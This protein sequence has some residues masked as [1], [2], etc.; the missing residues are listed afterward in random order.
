MAFGVG[1]TVHI[2]GGIINS[3]QK[4]N[5]ISEISR[6]K[7]VSI[8]AFPCPKVNDKGL[9]G[10]WWWADKIAI[11][12]SLWATHETWKAAKEEY[13]IGRRYYILAKEQWDHFYKYYR[14]LEDQELD[15]I[16]AELPYTPDYKTAVSGHTN[17]IDPVFI[18]TDA[19]L[20][21]LANK[22]CM[23]SDVSQFKKTEI[24]RST[25]RGDSDNF[26][27]RYAEKLAQEK[28]DIRWARRIAAIS[29]GRGL[30]SASTSFASKATGFFSQYAQ[31]MGGLAGSA[32]QFSGYVRNRFQTEYNPVRERIDGRT[33]VPNTYRGF[34]AGGYWN[35]R[36]IP[37]AQSSS[38]GLSW[39]N[40][41]IS[42][43][44]QSGFDPTGV[45]NP[46][47]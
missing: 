10:A 26:A 3:I 23:C 44:M 15:E 42:P 37:T 39:S 32:M 13:K 45:I 18:R 24:I 43:Y 33:D 8:K 29:R 27:R 11:A 34:D 40:Y 12:V 25:I 9:T 35:A 6:V 22:Y 16:W 30:L 47:Q 21:A 46:T 41:E 36:G 7:D 19:H 38:G 28:N 2:S 14:P 1:D 20:V 4:I 31:A 17:L 5:S